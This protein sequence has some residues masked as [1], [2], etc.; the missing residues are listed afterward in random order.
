MLVYLLD[1]EQ[2]YKTGGY[3][4]GRA[5]LASRSTAACCSWRI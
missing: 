4:L 1:C 5:N 3:Q 2:N